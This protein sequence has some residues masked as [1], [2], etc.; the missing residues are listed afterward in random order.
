MVFVTQH[1]LFG[2]HFLYLLSITVVKKGTSGLLSI[3]L[4]NINRFSIFFTVE[5]GNKFAT[6]LL[7]HYPPYFKSVATLPCEMTVVTKTFSY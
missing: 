2:T 5:F 7:L 3:T 1:L 4:A 6:K